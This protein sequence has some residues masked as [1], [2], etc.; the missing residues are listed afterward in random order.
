MNLDHIG[1][2]LLAIVLSFL[3]LRMFDARMKPT[4]LLWLP[5]LTFGFYW[6]LLNYCAPY[7]SANLWTNLFSELPYQMKENFELELQLQNNQNKP[8]KQNKN[9]EESAKDEYLK[10]I[11]EEDLKPNG[12]VVTAPPPIDMPNPP[13][14]V[15]FA[16]VTEPKNQEFLPR[17]P[18]PTEPPMKIKEAGV[19]PE[20]PL[21]GM[22][23]LPEELP[24][25]EKH[26]PQLIE[27]P[28]ENKE[29]R[30]DEAT[31]AT[32]GLYP[33]GPVMNEMAGLLAA[34]VPLESHPG[35]Q[36]LV[37]HSI[38][39][40]LARETEN[41]MV[42]PMPP[43]STSF[44]AAPAMPNNS[45]HLFVHS[46]APQQMFPQPEPVPHSPDIEQ[47][48]FCVNAP[49][50]QQ[51][52][53]VP[54]PVPAPASQ[55][56]QGPISPEFAWSMDS[57]RLTNKKDD[58]KEIEREKTARE[59]A[60]NSKGSIKVIPP[61]QETIHMNLGRER[62][63]SKVPIASQ[64]QP[65][66]LNRIRSPNEVPKDIYADKSGGERMLKADSWEYSFDGLLPKELVAKMEESPDLKK[67]PAC[68]PSGVILNSPWTEWKPLQ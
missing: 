18:L 9:K 22:P 16:T 3:V 53:P 46:T 5:L 34:P 62:N 10:A 20:L 1:Y 35:T 19:T 36:A 21:L 6:F 51:H 32:H 14:K 58:P 47:N 64:P 59:K 25:R 28:V 61:Q 2:F 65:T 15:T 52:A 48:F 8:N 43:Y 7:E 40:Q 66:S 68:F 55:K 33:N 57:S 41:Q 31:Q 29:L 27:A 67:Q 45:V 30:I 54:A 4:D 17:D 44:I 39:N 42:P 60:L 56:V 49:Q 38:M 63:N 23:V 37:Q 26:C 11:D 50:E 12:E 13:D 24:C